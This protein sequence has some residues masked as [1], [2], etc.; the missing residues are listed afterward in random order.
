[1]SVGCEVGVGASPTRNQ[2]VCR[3]DSFSISARYYTIMY[4]L[5]ARG[6]FKGTF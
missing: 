5:G 2:Q 4:I 3:L 1:M 6:Q